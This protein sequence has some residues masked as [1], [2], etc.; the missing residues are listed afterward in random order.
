M[1]FK[2][3]LLEDSENKKEN[4]LSLKNDRRIN[5]CKKYNKNNLSPI[6]DVVKTCNLSTMKSVV[7]KFVNKHENF[8]KTI[9]NIVGGDNYPSGIGP[10]E[11]IC[12]F[13]FDDIT[14]GGRNSTTD[15]L[16]NKKP[17][18]EVKAGKKISKPRDG[19][20]NG[21]I[22]DFKFGTEGSTAYL[23]FI[24]DLKKFINYYHSVF[25]PDNP[26]IDKWSELSGTYF[27]IFKKLGDLSKHKGSYP[28]SGI[29][30]SLMK[31]GDISI[32]KQPPITN[33][34]DKSFQ[35][36]MKQLNIDGNKLLTIDENISSFEKI[37][38]RWKN[39]IL[40]TKLSEKPFIFFDNGRQTGEILL[41]TYLTEDNL[42]LER[43]S[44]NTAKPYVSL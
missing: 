42:F 3:F 24:E 37:L 29:P 44:L 18:A 43:I 19:A 13:I 2:Q 39:N 35:A 15:L 8:C 38:S 7:N 1:I 41:V 11:I 6:D 20:P 25:D 40:S 28:T 32:E 17:F 31:D 10:G 34:N 14:L 26:K 4:S 22:A 9:Y 33:V 36:D 12:D 27:E 30:L 16:K 5:L 23:K 21:C